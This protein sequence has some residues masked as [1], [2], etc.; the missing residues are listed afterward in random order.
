M[1]NILLFILLSVT[2]YTLCFAQKIETK[3]TF[4]GAKYIQNGNRLTL[5]GL[6]NAMEPNSEASTY[7]MKA[8]KGSLISSVFAGAGGVCLGIAASRAI[9]GEDTSWSLI[10]AGVG[11]VAI[12]VPISYRSL[13]NIN[14][15][16]D[17]H[18]SSLVSA[19]PEEYN[20][21]MII[22][23]HGSRIG[24]SVSF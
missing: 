17:L 12:G 14:Q 11:L 1:K 19:I 7:M 15:A 22:F 13:R 24:L 4:W 21:E 2:S 5:K 10:G 16:I 20:A 23:A 3:N 6:V 8:K 18:N 9:Q